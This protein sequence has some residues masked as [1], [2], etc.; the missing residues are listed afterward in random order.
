MDLHAQVDYLFPGDRRWL[1]RILVHA[2]IDLKQVTTLEC[3]WEKCVLPGVPFEPAGMRKA[4]VTLDHIQARTNGGEDHWN[5][6]QLLHHTCNMRKGHNFTEEHRQKISDSV[7]KRWQDPE[8]RAT[9]QV[10]IAEKIRSSESRKRQSEAMKRHWADPERKAK[11]S[12]A[13]KR[14]ATPEVV[15]RRNAGIKK[16]WEQRKEEDS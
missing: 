6:T 16:S 4:C 3:A 5:N 2:L 15:A 8:Y 12:A 7:R 10:K 9:V 14:G 1:T 11:H 13:V